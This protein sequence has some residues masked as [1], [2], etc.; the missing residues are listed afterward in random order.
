[1]RAAVVARA[2]TAVAATSVRVDAAAEAAF[3]LDRTYTLAHATVSG[4]GR[5]TLVA[6]TGCKAE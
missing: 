6:A 4:S 1:M 3:V 2:L 5:A